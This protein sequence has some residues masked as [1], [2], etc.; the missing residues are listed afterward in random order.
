MSVPLVHA[1]RVRG[2][3]KIYCDLPGVFDERTTLRFSELGE[4]VA[5]LLE[6]SSTGQPAAG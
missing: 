5:Q 2:A 6:W 4:S 3:I 1:G